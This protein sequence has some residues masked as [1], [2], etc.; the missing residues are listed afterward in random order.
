MSRVPTTAAGKASIKEKTARPASGVPDLLHSDP[1]RWKVLYPAY[2]N[3]AK[4]VASVP[5]PL[6]PPPS[7]TLPLLQSSSP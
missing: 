2:F 6:P 3:A 1:K 7:P 4:T 5:Y